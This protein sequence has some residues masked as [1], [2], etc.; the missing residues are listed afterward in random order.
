MCICSSLNPNEQYGKIVTHCELLLTTPEPLSCCI[1]VCVWF[2]FGG[3][4]VGHIRY[5]LH[6][7][8]QGT[9]WR[10]ILRLVQAYST[11]TKF[12]SSRHWQHRIRHW[13]CIYIY[14]YTYILDI[15]IYI[16]IQYVC[17]YLYRERERHLGHIHM[18]MCIL[19]IH[20]YIYIYLY[21]KSIYV[22]LCIYI[23]IHE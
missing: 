19:Y 23:Y 13:I 12:S 4:R 5:K 14:I 18:Y 20:I 10:C 11:K 9:D 21:E 22:Y 15:D 1:C 7:K 2:S 8:S 16:A 6:E 3:G 17:I